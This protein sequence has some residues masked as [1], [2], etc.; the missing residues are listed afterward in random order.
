MEKVFVAQRVANKLYAT[1][2]AVDA[3]IVEVTEMMA[4]LVQ[5]IQFSLHAYYLVGGLAR[6]NTYA[7][8]NNLDSIGVLLCILV[9]TLLAWRR[10]RASA[11]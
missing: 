3:A 9:G 1:E 10:R 4:E 6:D 11:K 2:A 8:V 5:G 7:M